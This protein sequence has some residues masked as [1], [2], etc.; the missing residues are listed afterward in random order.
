VAHALDNAEKK[1][2]R[3]SVEAQRQVCPVFSIF[4]EGKPRDT[5]FFYT[6]KPSLP[7]FSLFA[8]TVKA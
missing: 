4:A 8:Y 7:T 3:F 1:T 6:S 2:L 5:S